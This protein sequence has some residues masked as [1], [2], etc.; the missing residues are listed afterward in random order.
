[1]N[2]NEEIYLV[3]FFFL[4]LEQCAG[5]GLYLHSSEKQKSTQCTYL[6]QGH[7]FLS[8]TN[9]LFINFYSRIPTVRGGFWVTY[10]GCCCS[11]MKKENKMNLFFF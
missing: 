9:T 10:E 1:L 5:A 4:N 11:A 3:L 2:L 6:Q 7:N 8:D